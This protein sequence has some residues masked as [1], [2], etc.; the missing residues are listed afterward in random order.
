M[1]SL[2]VG[3]K[4]V[5][6]GPAGATETGNSCP[7]AVFQELESTSLNSVILSVVQ[8]MVLEQ[9]CS[10]LWSTFVA[11]RGPSARPPNVKIKCNPTPAIVFQGDNTIGNHSEVWRKGQ[12]C[13]EH[14]TRTGDLRCALNL[15]DPRETEMKSQIP[16]QAGRKAVK[17]PVGQKRYGVGQSSELVAV[18]RFKAQGSQNLSCL[19]GP[20]VKLMPT[21]A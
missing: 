19:M 1:A 10:M 11:A 15:R 9:R 4:T 21:C 5:L 6:H 2:P 16:G 3:I 17:F 12:R 20:S 18:T 8:A 7:I 14:N 13:A